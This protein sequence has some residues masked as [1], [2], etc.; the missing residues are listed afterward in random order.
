MSA[1]CKQCNV[2]LVAGENWS[3]G[4]QRSRSYTCRHCNAA[5]GRAFYAANK[6]RVIDGAKARRNANR[7]KVRAYWVG[8]REANGEAM[9]AHETARRANR[10]ATVEGRATRILSRSKCQARAA[11][12]DHDLTLEWIER[13]LRAG[14]CEV[15]GLPFTFSPVRGESGSRT[16]PFSPSLDRIKQGGPYSEENTR[17]V[18]FIYNVARSDFSDNELMI[19]ARALTS[20]P[21]PT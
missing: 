9:R 17:M 14:V 19:L 1:L 6:S 3:S 20:G 18:V 10:L 5:K 16:H 12:V 7:E 13:R 2:S 4:M 11:K 21:N 8:H 15:T